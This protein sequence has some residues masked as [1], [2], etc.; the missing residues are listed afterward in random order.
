MSFEGTQ[1]LDKRIVRHGKGG[2][3]RVVLIGN[4]VPDASIS[5]ARGKLPD[6]NLSQAELVVIQG[7]NKEEVDLSSIRAL[8][9]EDF[10]KNSEQRLL[11]Q[12]QRIGELKLHLEHYQRYDELCQQIVPEMKVLYPAAKALSLAHSVQIQTDS[13]YTDTI[14]LAWIRYEGRLKEA[15]RYKLSEWLQARI[16]TDKLQLIIE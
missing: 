12:E 15:E 14:T 5:L 11:E 7:L 8:V 4:E 3:I 1:V 2:E 16:G 13:L 10:Y 6:Y 9:M